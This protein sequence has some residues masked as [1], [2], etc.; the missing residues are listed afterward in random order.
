[1]AA[2]VKT[3]MPPAVIIGATYTLRIAALDAATGSDVAG[4]KCSNIMIEIENLGGGGADELAFGPFMLV[5]G[6]GA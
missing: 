5:P 6:P 3:A 1:V 2:P 4:V